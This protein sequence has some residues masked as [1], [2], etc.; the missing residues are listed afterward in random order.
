MIHTLNPRGR[1]CY[2]APRTTTTTIC[3][4]RVDPRAP[5]SSNPDHGDICAACERELLWIAARART[6]HMGE[7]QLA[8]L[9]E[10]CR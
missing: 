6:K 2:V 9:Q 10:A 1:W 4:S 5:V 3:L 7:A 8:R